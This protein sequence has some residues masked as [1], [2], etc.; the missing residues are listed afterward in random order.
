MKM[1]DE[2]KENLLDI[3]KQLAWAWML[4]VGGGVFIGTLIGVMYVTGRLL[5]V[6]W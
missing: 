1:T 6:D 5:G 2:Q 3:L 4:A